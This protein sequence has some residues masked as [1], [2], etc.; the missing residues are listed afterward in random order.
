[1]VIVR[2]ATV[3]D[4]G[5]LV[6]LMRDF[7]AESNFPLDEAWASQ[8]FADLLA[9]PAAG[10]IWLIDVDGRPVGHVVL[11]IRYAME[12]A[13]LIGYIDDLYVRPDHRRRGAASAGV[14]MLVAECQRRG[15]KSLQVEVDPNNVPAIGTYRKFG[16][17]PGTDERLLLKT[18]LPA[19]AA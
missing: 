13:G 2:L 7:Y 6:D 16:M 1:V 12:F 11:S 17:A 15:C 3:A 9:N 8:S 5:V 18:N 4:I 19:P 14:A 10:T